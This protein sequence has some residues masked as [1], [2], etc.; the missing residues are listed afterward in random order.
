MRKSIISSLLAIALV[1]GPFTALATPINFKDVNVN[2]IEY[3]H[4]SKLSSLGVI[5]GRGDGT[6]GSHDSVKHLEALVM[7]MRFF[8]LESTANASHFRLTATVEAAFGGQVPEWGKGYLV[9]ASDYAFL[10]PQERFRWDEGASR[11]WVA[12]LLIRM[13]GKEH[14]ALALNNSALP[15]TDAHQI[16]PTDRGYIALATNLGLIRGNGDGT[17]APNR[18][19]TRA[20]MAIFLDRAEKRMDRLPPG[21][22]EA[23][24]IQVQEGALSVLNEK[25]LLTS[26]SLDNQAR[27]F[28]QER[29]GKVGDLKAQDKIRYIKSANDKI[30]YLE[31]IEE[32]TSVSPQ[33]RGELLLHNS[34]KGLMTIRVDDGFTTYALASNVKVINL[35]GRTL[36]TGQLTAGSKIQIRL[37]SEERIAEILVEESG[38]QGSEGTIVELSL[39]NQILILSDDT[40]NFPTYVIDNQTEVE[41]GGRRFA[42]LED[43]RK[44]DR[45]SVEA[46]GQQIVSKITLLQAQNQGNIQGT[47]TLIARDSR[48]LNVKSEDGQLYAYEIPRNTDI[49]FSNGTT[50]LLEDIYSH[51][52]VTVHLQGGTVEKIVLH[53]TAETK[54]IWG[55]IVSVDIDRRLLIV[56]DRQNELKSYEIK[57]SVILDIS[58]SNPRLSHLKVDSIIEFELDDGKVSYITIKDTQDGIV[59]RVDSDRNILAVRDSSGNVT[60]YAVDTHVEVELFRRSRPDLSDVNV[61]DTIR[62]RVT[63]DKVDRIYVYSKLA[64]EVTDVRISNNRIY[65]KDTNNVE[66]SYTISNN[67]K[68]NIDG[69]TKPTIS[70]VEKHQWA[71]VSYLGDKAESIFIQPFTRGEVTNVE[72]DRGRLTVRNYD[73][74]S[75]T[76]SIDSNLKVEKSGTTSSNLLNISTGDRVRLVLNENERIYRVYVA[77]KVSGKVDG[78]QRTLQEIYLSGSTVGYLIEG[79][80]YILQNGLRRT[81][82]DITHNQNVTIYYLSG[83][84]AVEVTLP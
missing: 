65:V 68:L 47:V 64:G 35:Q 30:V 6:F 25:R 1:T 26:L 11:A 8:G 72:V 83:Y 29:Q 84:K 9:T 79:D 36:T 82:E 77:R 42:S 52:K 40:G 58:E 18:T 23:T 71:I 57:D 53:K 37:N 78:I 54:A 22:E 69:I 44:G 75:K 28:I 4:I 81:F 19:V 56:R 12:K 2:A 48:V 16:A 49:E 34:E 73:G 60:T 70:D 59:T 32:G 50:A 43:L 27:V 5:K 74:T 45:V 33:L 10:G 63:N 13:L 46:D 66:R 15:F 61:D 76:Y 24:I 80:T 7:V 17:F 67:L 31:V 39:K 51:D 62:F 55:K 3:R 21:I 41:Y 20:E 38:K 14:E